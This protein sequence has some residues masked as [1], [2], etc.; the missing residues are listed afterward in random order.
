MS[1]VLGL[2]PGYYLMVNN[3]EVTQG[4]SFCHSDTHLMEQTL[5]QTTY[6]Y[7]NPTLIDQRGSLFLGGFEGARLRASIY[8]TTDSIAQGE[9]DGDTDVISC[10]SV[11][12][13]QI[14]TPPSVAVIGFSIYWEKDVNSA[15]RSSILCCRSNTDLLTSL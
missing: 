9:G 3:L 7:L 2:M 11:S 5:S 4:Y 8:I 12:S 6:C 14:N 1:K 10:V 13:P 15:K